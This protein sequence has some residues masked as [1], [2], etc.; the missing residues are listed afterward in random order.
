VRRAAVAVDHVRA[1]LAAGQ[2]VR[3][4]LAVGGLRPIAT[5][6][7]RQARPYL[8]IRPRAERAKMCDGVNGIWDGEPL[9]IIRN[10]IRNRTNFNTGRVP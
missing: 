2:A 6:A 5:T 8:Q 7:G 1:G 9:P 3:D 10:I 4:L